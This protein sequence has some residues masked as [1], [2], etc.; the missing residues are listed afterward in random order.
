M[1]QNK[2]NINIK[3]YYIGLDPG[4]AS[5][6][7]AVTNFNYDLLKYKGKEMWGVRLYDE[8][9]TAEARRN[10]RCQRR[11]L[12]RRKIRLAQLE[13]L[14][15]NEVGKI[16]S[17]FFR[18]MHDSNLWKEDKRDNTCKYSLFNDKDFTD[19]EYLEKYPTAYHLRSELVHSDDFHDIRLVYLAIHHILKSR[20]HFLYEADDENADKNIE[21]SLHDLEELLSENDINFSIGDIERF[22][23]AL[24]SQ[25]SITD[26]KIIL[27]EAYSEQYTKDKQVVAILELLAGATVRLETLFDEENYKDIDIKSISLRDDL[28]EKYNTLSNDLSEEQLDILLLLKEI[29]DTVRL[30]QVLGDEKYLCDAKIKLYK[31]NKDDLKIIQQYTKINYPEKYDYIFKKIGMVKDRKANA[32]YDIYLAPDSNPK[33]K[34]KLVVKQAEF[35]ELLKKELPNLKKEKEI[36][37]N[38]IYKEISDGCF[39]TKLKGSD[40]GLVPYQL[41]LKE[42]KIILSKASKYHPFLNKKDEDGISIGDKI[43]SI[44]EFKIPYYVGPLSCD[45]KNSFI[46]K[47]SAEKIYPWNFE[48]TVDKKESSK[49]FMKNLIGRCTYTGDYVLPRDSLLYSRYMLLNELNNIKI[50]GKAITYENK[51]LIISRLFENTTKNITLKDIHN[52]LATNGL[53]EKRDEISGVDEKINSKLNSYNDFK[54]ILNRTHDTKMVEDIIEHIVVY[55]KDKNMLKEWLLSKYSLQ[56]DEIKTILRLKYNKWGKLSERFLTHIKC[57]DPETHICCS[58]MDQLEHNTMNLMMLLSS[59]YKYAEIAQ[60]YKEKEY[61]SNLNTIDSIID[62]FYISP[63]AKRSIKQ[64]TKLVDEIVDIE[65]G[66]PKKLFIEMARDVS[67][68]KK[69][70]K[71]NSRKD[72]LLN[73]YKN[74]KEQLKS[75]DNINDKENSYD[76]IYS[77]LKMES[78]DN[79]RRDKLFLYYTQFGRCMYSGEIIDLAKCLGDEKTYDIDHI[80]PQSKI[81]DN[82]LDNRVLVKSELNR[83]KSDVYPI[84]DSI[85]K[86]MKDFWKMLKDKKLISS[87]KYERL[88][89]NTELTD[90]E[91]RSF[92]A[93]Q[94]VE[95]RQSSKAI[96]T[97]FKKLYPNSKI[98]YSKAGNISSFRQDFQILKFRDINDYHHAKDAYLNIVVGNVYD[99]KFTSYFL[100]NIRY[101]KYSLNKIFDYD[102]KNAWIAPTKIEMQKYKGDLKNKKANIYGLSG[103]IETVYRYIFKNTPIVTYSQKDEKG[104]LYDLNILKRGEGQLPI[105]KGM[106]IDK[107]GGYNAIT[108]S[109]YTVVKHGKDSKKKISILPVCLTH[110]P[111]FEKNQILYCQRILNKENPE[112]ITKKV[113]INSV[114]EFDGIRYLICGRGDNRNYYSHVYQLAI[115]DDRAKYIKSLKK[116]HDRYG[117]KKE[118]PP[119]DNSTITKGNNLSLY[120]WYVRKLEGTIY[121]K[122]FPSIGDSLRNASELFIELSIVDQVFV[123]LELL[124]IFKADRTCSNLNLIG[125]KGKVGEIRLS[126]NISNFKSAYLINQSVTGLY[127][128]RNDLLK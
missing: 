66:A 60:N 116:F 36:N 98:V 81:K 13:M 9:Q 35:C 112:I 85:R 43:I 93:R 99:T 23:K 58:V 17:S 41:N 50:N 95:T 61:Y 40:N 104:A 67:D 92:V 2:N 16:D 51:E 83:N 53:I 96:A 118:E 108:G 47:N 26:K 125:I 48:R 126:Q 74:C 57:E 19:K 90:D 82:S 12:N 65:K 123:L 42:L 122:I 18:R 109:Y 69:K 110:V 71:T 102:V 121:S 27:K 113:S 77:R 76:N 63:S 5:C 14:F 94:L 46:V 55:G 100:D 62:D 107:Y 103:T 3:D 6:G 89:R 45:A 72:A 4:S 80:Y 97:I 88:V 64:A 25:E 7:W 70:K 24:N 87:K 38:R 84:N 117:N 106:D 29:F 32:K 91:L 20:G 115:D 111:M 124:K 10:A 34:G 79:L 114:F 78:E 22:K 127:E 39:L 86:N 52:L 120:N 56:D 59:N 37:L 73:L 68:K 44:F 101:E 33:N 119:L 11:R 30:K 8:A 28:D 54:K 75:L 31:K 15:N 105:K 21:E 128:V 1:K 49:K